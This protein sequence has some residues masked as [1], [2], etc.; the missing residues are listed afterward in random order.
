MQNVIRHN[1]G[2]GENEQIQLQDGINKFRNKD[3]E[4]A[5]IDFENILAVKPD[6]VIALYYR[7]QIALNMSEP[8]P[9]ISYF[10]KANSINSNS[11]DVLVALALAHV[12]NTNYS[13]ALLY[14]EK[15]REIEPERKDIISNILVL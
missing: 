1:H 5:K 15:A 7:G 8:G 14:F 6:S 10:E 4:K 13:V 3:Y 11:V 9:A 12:K 2:L